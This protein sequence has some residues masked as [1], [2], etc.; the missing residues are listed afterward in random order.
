MTQQLETELARC[1]PGMAARLI[2]I[3]TT[4]LHSWRKL[5]KIGAL[6]TPAG[7]WLFDVRPSFR[8]RTPDHDATFEFHIAD[9]LCRATYVMREKAIAILSIMDITHA[10]YQHPVRMDR[11]FHDAVAGLI[12][13]DKKAD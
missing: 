8:T 1:S 5:G 3:S 10:A 9:S 11:E 4:T 2:G 12:A 6:Q 13:A 7:R